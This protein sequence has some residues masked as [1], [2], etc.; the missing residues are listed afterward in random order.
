DP[1]AKPEGGSEQVTL[2]R[3][4]LSFGISRVSLAILTAGNSISRRRRLYTACG[5]SKFLS[6]KSVVSKEEGLNRSWHGMAL[7]LPLVN[8]E[9][10]NKHGIRCLPQNRRGSRREH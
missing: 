6:F 9:R 5:N 10:R 2:V 4:T 1:D 8:S 7:P 3:D